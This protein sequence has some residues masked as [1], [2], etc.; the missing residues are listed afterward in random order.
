MLVLT[1]REGEM[2]NIGDDIFIKVIG[3][4]GGNVRI[5]VDA[6]KDTPVHRNEIYNRIIVNTPET[7]DEP[8]N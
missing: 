1:R 8:A 5:G 6:P 2:I 4:K 7:S 3:V